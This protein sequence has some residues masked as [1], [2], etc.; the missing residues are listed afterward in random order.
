[1]TKVYLPQSKIKVGESLNEI[2][3]NLNLY[4][5]VAKAISGD[6][7]VYSTPSQELFENVLTHAAVMLIISEGGNIENYLMIVKA[8]HEIG[9]TSIYGIEVP[10][11]LPN[12]TMKV[13]DGTQ[14]V[15][16]VKNLSQW[17]NSNISLT[18]SD[19]YQH[20]YLESRP[21]GNELTGKELA[22][23]VNQLGVELLTTKEFK[24]LI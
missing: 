9:T 5:D 13:T 6:F 19:D 18:I 17:V 20:I 23:L 21:L 2:A 4:G 11:G 3:S 12:R 8:P 10:E 7:I 24:V 15:E 1:M 16:S 14:I 22:I